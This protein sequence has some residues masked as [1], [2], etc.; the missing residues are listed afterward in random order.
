[1][2]AKPLI[3]DIWSVGLLGQSI[4]TTYGEEKYVLNQ[5]TRV[6]SFYVTTRLTFA[7][8]SVFHTKAVLNADL[9][10]G[11]DGCL[12]IRKTS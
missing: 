8:N 10:V 4:Q 2:S 9:G 7:P 1:M 5:P 3:S 12:S 6:Q 11:F